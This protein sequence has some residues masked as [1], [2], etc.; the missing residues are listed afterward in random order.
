MANPEQY[1]GERRE[2]APIVI[3]GDASI[4][5]VAKKGETFPITLSQFV[6]HGR[7]AFI[8]STINSSSALAGT[9]SELSAEE[10]LRLTNGAGRL[11][12]KLLDG[13]PIKGTTVLTSP[14]KEKPDIYVATFGDSFN[15]NGLRLYFHHG[16][17]E[18]ARVLYQD[19][20]TKI[21]SADKVERVFRLAGYSAPKAWGNRKSS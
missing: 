13:H 14:E 1:K 3:I 9:E 15:P 18:G 21:K 6:D 11:L 20:R 2:A 4:V 7:P 8:A 16:I 12:E 10:R 5:P 17:Y 19:A